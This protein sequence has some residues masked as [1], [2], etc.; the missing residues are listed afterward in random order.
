GDGHHG[1]TS[2]F[3][4]DALLAQPFESGASTAVLSAWEDLDV[5]EMTFADHTDET[6]EL[7][8]EEQLGF[9]GKFS[10]FFS[11]RVD[12]QINNARIVGKNGFQVRGKTVLLDTGAALDLMPATLTGRREGKRSS[13]EGRDAQLYLATGGNVTRQPL[14]HV[15][16][17][18]DQNID[19][20]G[21]APASFTLPTHELELGSVHITQ[22]KGAPE[23]QFA[24]A[25]LTGGADGGGSA[26]GIVAL[27]DGNLV[28]DQ[29][30][31]PRCCT[32]L[33]GLTLTEK[34][35]RFTRGEVLWNQKSVSVESGVVDDALPGRLAAKMVAES[36]PAVK[37]VGTA[38]QGLLAGARDKA[39][40]PPPK[41][42][43]AGNLLLL[44]NQSYDPE[45]QTGTADFT[46]SAS[47]L[48]QGEY[49]L[50]FG[51]VTAGTVGTKF[52]L[53]DQGLISAKLEDLKL[54]VKKKDKELEGYSVV[55]T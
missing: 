47:L 1:P 36:A 52:T 38:M 25:T 43:A 46:L 22:K 39:V 29:L 11:R 17:D 44:S 33:Y 41:S 35:L 37:T 53:N 30:N 10:R 3:D 27:Q 32:K 4:L 55:L 16:M 6:P 20:Q 18:S 54:T 24:S 48:T 51:T 40:S 5:S 21:T 26:V 8:E 7:A 2:T 34:E 49:G 9:G 23:I 42:T 50:D 45:K 13:A 12:F 28:M 31:L 14:D 15:Y 19:A